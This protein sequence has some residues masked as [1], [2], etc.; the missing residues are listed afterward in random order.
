MKLPNQGQPVLGESLTFTPT[1]ELQEAFR[2][3]ARFLLA[4]HDAVLEAFLQETPE[5]RADKGYVAKMTDPK[6]KLECQGQYFAREGGMQ[7]VAYEI[8]VAAKEVLK[9]KKA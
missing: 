3:I 6:F 4:K 2:T 1:P 7:A 8:L 5:A 9:E